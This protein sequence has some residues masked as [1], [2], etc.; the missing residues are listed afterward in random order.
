MERMGQ[1]QSWTAAR[2]R[3]WMSRLVAARNMEK[4][5]TVNRRSVQRR[6]LPKSLSQPW[7][8]ATAHRSTTCPGAETQEG[9]ITPMSSWSASTAWTRGPAKPRSQCTGNP[10]GSG[11]RVPGPSSVSHSKALSGWFAPAA[12]RCNSVPV[13]SV[14]SERLA[15]LR[16]AAITVQRVA[17]IRWQVVA[18]E[19]RKLRPQRHQQ[20]SWQGGHAIL[21]R[22]RRCQQPHA[23]R[24]RVRRL[25]LRLGSP[26]LL[27]IA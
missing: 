27:P 7:V 13:T 19:C 3:R 1:R 25:P 18:R 5:V 6:R 22:S 11:P 12:A 10:G 16:S 21:R 24:T 23:R 26:C 17:G 9:G 2:R 14:H 4:S 15:A 20:R 8:R